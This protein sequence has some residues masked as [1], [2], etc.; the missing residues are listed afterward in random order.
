MYLL[1][2]ASMLF[3]PYVH[4]Y[5]AHCSLRRPIAGKCEYFIILHVLCLMSNKY[6]HH[7]GGENI[8][9]VFL[10]L[11]CSCFCSFFFLVKVV[12]VA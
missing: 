3:L 5:A 11:H 7:L 2:G 8:K 9:N 1:S 6:K 10:T 4:A 12:N